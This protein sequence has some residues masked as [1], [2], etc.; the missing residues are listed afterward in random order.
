MEMPPPFIESPAAWI[1]EEMARHK[2]RWLVE[3]VP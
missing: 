2:E 3:L 1:G